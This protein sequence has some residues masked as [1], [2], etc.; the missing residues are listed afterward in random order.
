M[1]SIT[2]N[3]YAALRGYVNGRPRLEI[4][5]EDGQTIQQVLQGLAIPVEQ[6]RILMV[7]GR[8]ASLEC[9]LQPGDQLG[10]FPAI[11]GG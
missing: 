4:E 1:A 6:T 11:G 9:P 2:L 8:A 7:N 3:L 5:I 10:V